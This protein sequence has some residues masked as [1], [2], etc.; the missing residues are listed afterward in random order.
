M[1]IDNLILFRSVRSWQRKRGPNYQS[2]LL[3]LPPIATLFTAGPTLCFTHAYPTL[4]HYTILYHWPEVIIAFV[5]YPP[6]PLSPASLNCI[7][8][9]DCN[10]RMYCE[11]I[12]SPYVDVVC[13]HVCLYVWTLYSLWWATYLPLLLTH[14]SNGIS[15]MPTLFICHT[16]RRMCKEPAM[17]IRRQC[18]IMLARGTES[19]SAVFNELTTRF[20]SG[21][22]LPIM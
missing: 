14:S 10:R 1:T 6:P 4:L 16:A 13:A 19:F 2:Y 3:C 17:T 20:T 5:I 15:F 12:S 22:A 7:V 11:S 21:S 9:S 8:T 18:L